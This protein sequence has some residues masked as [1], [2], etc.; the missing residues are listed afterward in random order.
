MGVDGYLPPVAPSGKNTGGYAGSQNRAFKCMKEPGRER[1]TSFKSVASPSTGFAAVGHLLEISSSV[2]LSSL[3]AEIWRRAKIAF[4]PRGCQYLTSS[5]D[6]T[7]NLREQT[8]SGR[9]CISEWGHW[10]D[11]DL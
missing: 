10:H 11:T 4:S 9:Q 7:G 5:P 6:G 1:I 3:G 2:S 8:T